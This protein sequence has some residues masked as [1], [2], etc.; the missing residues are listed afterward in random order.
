MDICFV[1]HPGIGLALCYAPGY[2]IVGEYFNKRKGLAMSLATVGGGLGNF[3]FPP[4]IGALFQ[5]YG[6]LGTMSLLAALS[7]HVVAFAA[8][9]RP[10]KPTTF[11]KYFKKKSNK[12]KNIAIACTGMEKQIVIKD[13]GHEK[14]QD[15]GDLEVRKSLNNEID[16]KSSKVEE[17]EKPNTNKCYW[18]RY[19]CEPTLWRNP[20]ILLFL[21]LT[22]NVMNVFMSTANF[23]PSLAMDMGI[24][25]KKATFLLSIVGI[26]D[27]I[28]RVPFG[29]LYDWKPIKKVRSIVY[30]CMISVVG[31]GCFCM[32]LANSYGALVFLACIRGSLSGTF[33]AQRATI[34]HDYVGKEL[35]SQ[36]FGLL[37]FSTCLGS[38]VARLVGG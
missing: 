22:F 19:T 16:E 23:M 12:E 32:P 25:S 24:G 4:V 30:I 18:L 33:M 2:I 9:Y 14:F 31:I 7:L 38:L 34:L 20:P 21:L 15:N 36:A 6:Y 5:T 35:V 17:K 37:L 11:G 1:M 26:S 10:L 27:C 29:F 28:A 8:L 13:I 3:I